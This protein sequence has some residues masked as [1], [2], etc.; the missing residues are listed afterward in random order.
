MNFPQAPQLGVPQSDVLAQFVNGYTG[1]P[2]PP[3][4]LRSDEGSLETIIYWNAPAD[5]RGI[6]GW[7]LY[8]GTETN[9]IW[10][11]KDPTRRQ[12]VV[13]MDADSTDIFYLSS[14]SKLG[15]ESAKPEVFA[16]SNTDKLV[17]DGTTGETSGTPASPIPEWGSEPSGGSG[18]EEEI[19][20]FS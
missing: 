11:T 4:G 3:R 17:V 19:L 5:Q 10:E 13:K 2:A 1:R 16:S 9:K 20:V 18:A 14:F 12:V 6:A 7:R 8:R 15:R